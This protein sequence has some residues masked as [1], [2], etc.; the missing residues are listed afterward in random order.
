MALKRSLWRALLRATCLL[1]GTTCLAAEGASA[2][3]A[4]APPPATGNCPPRASAWEPKDGWQAAA[5][6]A[7]D[8]GLLWRLEKG[9]HVSWLYGTIHVARAEWM[10]PGPA[11]REA[12]KQSDAVALELDL[13]DESATKRAFDTRKDAADARLMTGARSQRMNRLMTAACVTDPLAAK[14]RKL[15][16]AMQLATLSALEVR[17]DGLYPDFGI[18]LFLTGYAK[19]AQVPILPLETV[20]QQLRVLDE[21][22]PKKDQ[23]QQIDSAL[24]AMESGESRT[25]ML[26]LANAWADGDIGTLEHYPQWCDCLKTAA[27]RRAFRHLVT[28]RN[29]AMADNIARAHTRGKRVFG[30][31]G[32][33][34]MIGPKGLP[35]LLAAR[36]F[37]VTPVVP[38]AASR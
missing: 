25:Q 27:D 34:H 20:E 19:R 33:L 24:D 12:L 16:P 6:R 18:D 14:L 28:D 8:H 3:S 10:L 35:A 32:A 30:A 13:T 5:Q 11:I 21:I 15:A 1:A 7:T 29:R 4:D 22:L 36:G 2:D 37:A 17:A 31:V 38:P 23:A 26:T 9:G